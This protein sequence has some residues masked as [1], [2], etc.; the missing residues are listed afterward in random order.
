MEYVLPRHVSQFMKEKNEFQTEI[1]NH[2]AE[3]EILRRN[4]RECDIQ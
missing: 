2:T 3:K 4:V 1:K